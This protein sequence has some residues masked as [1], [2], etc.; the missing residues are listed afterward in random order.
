MCSICLRACTMQNVTVTEIRSSDEHYA[1]YSH[2]FLISADD[3]IK[4]KRKLCAI[5]KTSLKCIKQHMHC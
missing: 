1:K 5:G 3:G 2:E 4:V